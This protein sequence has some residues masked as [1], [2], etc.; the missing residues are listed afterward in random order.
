MFDDIDMIWVIMPYLLF[1][2][3]VVFIAKSRFPILTMLQ[4][5]LGLFSLFLAL[6]IFALPS[7]P[8]LGTFGYPDG[9]E[10]IATPEKTLKFLQ[11]YNSAI[12]RNTEVLHWFL[13]LTAV[14]FLSII[15]DVIKVIKAADLEMN[16]DEEP[17]S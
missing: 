9:I 11:R 3:V 13:F 4:I 16:V 2:V 14:F 8:S 7:T 1:Y 12:V 10:N 6:M 17:T 15:N 5:R